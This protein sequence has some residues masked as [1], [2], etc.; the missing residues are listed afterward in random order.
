VSELKRLRWR[1]DSAANWQAVNPVLLSGE[2][3]LVTAEG[4]SA[5]AWRYKIG[6]GATAWN[7]LAFHDTLLPLVADDDARL[8][9][10]RTPTAHNQAWSTITSTPTTRS[11][12]GI[13]DAAANG[14]VGSSGL[15]Q[16]TAKLLGRGTAGVGAIEEITLGTGLSLSGTTLNATGGSGGGSGYIWL[17]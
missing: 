6:D 12:Y 16:N 7:S 10:A 2:A 13:T 5:D 9:D 14:A 4:G 11:G 3:G 17:F 15:T 1:R 8:S